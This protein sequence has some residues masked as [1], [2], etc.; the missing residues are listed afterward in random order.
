MTENNRRGKFGILSILL[1]LYFGCMVVSWFLNGDIGTDILSTMN[2][3][4]RNDSAY[5]LLADSYH[6]LLPFIIAG[7]VL[8][9][10]T[11]VFSIIDYRK[12]MH[13]SSLCMII[14]ACLMMVLNFI[15]A[16][17]ILVFDHVIALN[18]YNVLMYTGP[19]S[20]QQ[21]HPLYAILLFV[22]AVWLFRTVYRF[23]KHSQ[24]Q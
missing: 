18:Y 20:M 14:A 21:L 13:E 1:F 24:A 19:F 3:Q 23:R 6:R 7:L 16:V 17:Y 9:L 15:P 10:A 4:W 11:L 22:L 2:G 5:P 12:T 8:A